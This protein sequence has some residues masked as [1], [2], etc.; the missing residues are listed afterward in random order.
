MSLVRSVVEEGDRKRSEGRDQDQVILSEEQ[1]KK[2]DKENRQFMEMKNV[3][4]I[5]EEMEEI[6]SREY[7]MEQY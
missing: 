7:E 5:L 1:Q 6:K 3:E 4:D 2:R